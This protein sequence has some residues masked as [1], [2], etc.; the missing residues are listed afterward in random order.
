MKISRVKV[1]LKFKYIFKSLF[2]NFEKAKLSVEKKLT[3]STNKK[4]IEFFGMCRTSFLVI[5]EY[6][7]S[8]KPNK[9]ELIVCSYNLEEMID[10]ARLYDFK[11]KLIDINFETGVM[12]FD[13]IKSFASNKTAAILFTNMF[14]N[15]SELSKLN[16]FCKDNDILMIE[17]NAIYYG[18]Y[19]IQDSKKEFSGSYG[20]VSIFSFGI[21]KNVSAIFGGALL[22]SNI[23]IYNFASM[24]NKQ[25]KN[26]PKK[27]YISKFIL[28]IALKFLLSKTIYNIFFFYLIQ[29]AHD[30]KIKKL[31]NLIYPSLKF[32]KKNKIPEE[33]YSKIPKFSIKLINQTIN[34]HEFEQDRIKRREN[35]K[36]YADLL[37]SNSNIKV[38]DIKDFNFQN[39]LDFPIL[40]KKDKEN[41]VKYLFKNGLE[42]RYYFYSNFEKYTNTNLNKVAELYDQNILCLPSH[43]E[44]G[45]EK[46]KKYCYEINQFYKNETT[47]Y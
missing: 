40:I 27:L 19:S 41:L 15:Y 12:N 1:Y 42:T 16:K 32:K 13:Q 26:F 23:D 29:I 21:M 18:N 46:I 20:D 25:F 45:K 34:D 7:K 4:Y 33:Y 8:K 35:N 3:Q 10:I 24:K 28:Y 44:I 36:L 9:D 43:S 17:D 14:N 39:F 30:Q 31:L 22:T 38:L 11:T 2:S 5:L 37:L 47:N 6:L